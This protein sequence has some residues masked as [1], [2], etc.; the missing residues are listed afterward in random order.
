MNLVMIN[1]YLVLMTVALG[2]VM[3]RVL[4][5]AG[6]LDVQIALVKE[7]ILKVNAQIVVKVGV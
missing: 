6:L 3:V 2:I 4:T 1:V 5:V 7:L